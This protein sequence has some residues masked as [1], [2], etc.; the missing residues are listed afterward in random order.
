MDRS[1]EQ[2]VLKTDL[3]NSEPK[4]LHIDYDRQ[5]DTLFL[6][7]GDGPAPQSV[8]CYLRDGVFALF[9]P[10]SMQVVGFQVEEWQAT[11]LKKQPGLMATWKKSQWFVRPPARPA[12][13]RQGVYR[14]LRPFAPSGTPGLQCGSVA[15]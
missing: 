14:M 12:D 5:L 11:F 1:S 2:L 8:A 13:V 10:E 6:F 9:D 3:L 15:S 4:Q 7:L